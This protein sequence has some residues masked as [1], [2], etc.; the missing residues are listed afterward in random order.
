MEVAHYTP[1]ALRALRALGF[2]ILLSFYCT[3][4]VA[5][6]QTVSVSL[7]VPELRV[8]QSTDLTLSYNATDNAKTSGLGLRLHFDSSAL[9]MGATSDTLREGAQPFQIRSDSPDFDN[10]PDTDKF[11]LT[12]WA[13]LS[14]VGWPDIASQPVTLYVVPLTAKSDFAGEVL[15]FSG[16]SAPGYT[17]VAADITIV[18]AETPVIT[19]LGETEV[20]LELGSTY[21]DAGA[22]AA[23][24][25]D[26]DITSNIA[27]VSTVD[28]NTVGTYTVTYNVSDTAGNAA[29]Q[30]TRTVN[31]TPD[32]TIPVITLLGESEVSLELGSTYIDAGATAVDNID[33]DI[34]ANIVTVNA[35][36]VNTVGTYTV[37]YNVSDAA[38]NAA[39][40]VTRTVN[41]TPD[42]TIPVITLLGESEVSL[43]LGSTYIDAGATAVDN[44]DG[45]ITA[46][47]VTVNAVDV[48]TVG[49]YTVTYNVS[50]A[51]GNAAIQVTRTVNITPDVTIPVI[52]LSGEA[53]VSLELG[54]TYID[55]GA[56]AVDN[57]DGDITANI[58]TVNAVDVNT[59]GTYTVTYNV[60]DAA[61]NAASQISRTVNITPDV[62]I[63]IITLLGEVEVSLELGSIFTDAGATAVDN[64][65]GDITA[66]IV[67]VNS[68]D[69][70]LVGT[71]TVTYN[72]SD[73]AGNAASQ[74]SRTV[75]IT[76]DVTIPVITLLGE[77]E[78]SLELGSIF[79]DAGATAADN[80]DGN[81]T[82]NIVTVNSVDVNMV[83]TYTVTYNVSDEAGNAATQ[84]TRTV[85][86]TPD[87]TIP[88]ITLLG[89]AEVSLELGSTY[90]DA[91]AT[92]ADNFDGDITAS[93]AVFNPVDVNTVGTYTVTFNVSDAAGNLAVPVL[94]QVMVSG[95]IDID[96]NG[97]YDALTD[98]LLLLRSIFGLDGD[99]LVFGAVASNAT[100]TSSQDILVEI[101]RLGMLLDIDGNGV[102]D[103]L[104]DGLLILRYLFGLEGDILIAGVVAQN[105]TR[106]TA[107]EIEAHLAGLTPTQ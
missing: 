102:I 101:D 2:L 48:N 73:E 105:A 99:A 84:V 88:V 74:V 24:N 14:G 40:Q 103:A 97:H 22:T 100:V 54:S 35:V 7:S 11:F 42:V 23:D 20:S 63:P 16:Y 70:N 12:A 17:L 71:Y 94:R 45:D 64:I 31:I 28:V 60:S 107:A 68:V 5:Q 96:R 75:N 90:T 61:G 80:I 62:T 15:A 46:N 53:E 36:D 91:G 79:T 32:V 67:T 34:T 39:I 87:L 10:N 41:I 85:N 6:E 44:I 72:V 52:T 43:E 27:V 9:E 106:A 57:I 38:G 81:I 55:A 66:N 104:T 19:L 8:G 95:I 65:D 29:T 21:T 56:T 58:V 3:A 98:G 13:D 30:V 77:S 82:A 86:I 51:A 89:E 76:P 83:G 1:R 18:K 69:V 92:A 50:D 47:I 26:G 33:G 78:V 4:A 49:T 59:V 93:I 25:I 37:T